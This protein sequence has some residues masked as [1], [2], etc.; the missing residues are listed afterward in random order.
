[1]RVEKSALVP[2]ARQ[3]RR[4]Q[5]D[6]EKHLWQHLRASQI[7][8]IKFKRQVPVA[9]YIADF[10]C[11]QAKLIVELD[12]GQHAEQVSYDEARTLVLQ[13]HGFTVLRFWNNEVFE[14]LD[15]VLMRIVE[16]LHACQPSPLPSPKLGRGSEEK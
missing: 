2:N 16:Q 3:L 7:E 13:Q 5:T 15:G 9:G 4:D 8:G 1:V 14:N 11:V 12:G 10:L 6:A